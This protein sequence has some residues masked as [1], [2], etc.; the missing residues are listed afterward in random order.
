MSYAQFV[1]VM[2]HT[3]TS[4][5]DV[6]KAWYT[7]ATMAIAMLG[8]AIFGIRFVFGKFSPAAARAKAE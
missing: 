1:L 8:A 7:G 6:G 5:S 4:G 3:L 2:A